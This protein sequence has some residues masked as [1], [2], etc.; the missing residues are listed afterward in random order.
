MNVNSTTNIG[1]ARIQTSNYLCNWSNY[2]IKIGMLTAHLT[3]S[4]YVYYQLVSIYM[5]ILCFVCCQFLVTR[6][7]LFLKRHFQN[8][9]IMGI[10]LPPKFGFFQGNVKVSV[11]LWE[12]QQV[13]QGQLFFWLP[14]LCLIQ[15][16][17][18][19]SILKNTFWNLEI[20]GMK[21]TPRYWPIWRVILIPM[22]SRF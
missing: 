17:P 12:Q 1:Y 14:H 10:K 6:K 7:N 2:S 20:M 18:K 3:F 16:H 4:S 11:V 8:L 5:F 19:K 9:E 13:M 22:I 15:C 21:N